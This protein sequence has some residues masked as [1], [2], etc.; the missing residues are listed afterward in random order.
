[1]LA[2][3]KNQH[4]RQE[5]DCKEMKRGKELGRKNNLC[6]KVIIFC[7]NSNLS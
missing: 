3:Y 5:N 2:E 4:E 1:M 7:Y 6:Q